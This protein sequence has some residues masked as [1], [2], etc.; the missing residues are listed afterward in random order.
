MA[1]WRRHKREFKRQAVERMKSCDNVHE[2]ARELGIGRK[3]L[4]TWK[5]QFE[6]RPEPSHASY[7]ETREE[8][9]ERKL[10]QEIAQLK[11]AL[12]DRSQ[13]VFHQRSHR[14]VE[15]SRS[16]DSC[17]RR[18]DSLLRGKNREIRIGGCGRNL[19]LSNIDQRSRPVTSRLGDLD[20]R[21]PQPEIERLPSNCRSHCRSPHTV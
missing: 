4:Y 12:A 21:P 11:Q 7:V 13:L 17:F 6:G 20:I 19:E 10:K 2:L 14:L 16:F 9:T 3:L 15:N 8:T 1:R 5:H 18:R